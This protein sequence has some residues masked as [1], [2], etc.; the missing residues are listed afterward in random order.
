MQICLSVSIITSEVEYLE[1]CSQLTDSPQ[2]VTGAMDFA[3]FQ[4]NLIDSY[5]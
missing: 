3:V 5:V 4:R 2:T 1:R